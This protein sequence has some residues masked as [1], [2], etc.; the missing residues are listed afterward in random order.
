MIKKEKMISIE[1]LRESF[2]QLD[3]ICSKKIATSLFLA[4]KIG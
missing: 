2:G 1:E 3:Y 4:Y